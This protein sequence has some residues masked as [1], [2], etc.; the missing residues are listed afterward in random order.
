MKPI[1]AITTRTLNNEQKDRYI[2]Q[3][4]YC[5]A[6]DTHG[7]SYISVTPNKENNYTHIVSMCDGL[8]VSGGG[9]I[10]ASYYNEENHEKADL[11]NTTLDA[12]DMALIDAFYKA[13]KPILGI[14]RGFQAL[15]VYFKGCLY[16]DLPSQYTSNINH[17][18]SEAREIG[19]HTITLCEDCFLGSKNT[20]HAVNTFHHQAVKTIGENLKI[21]AYSTEDNIVEAFEYKN[22]YATQWHPECMIH[23]AFH[24]DIFKKFIQLCKK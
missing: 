15:N 4:T 18:Q 22:I 16:Q 1:I 10:D 13:N 2:T 17:R 12:M 8:L 23:D 5:K 9:D 19:T 24:A 3:E 11:I 6:L 20:V 21:V 7:A 14:C